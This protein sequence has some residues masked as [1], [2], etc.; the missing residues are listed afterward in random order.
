[1]DDP[2]VSS[3]P[4]AVSAGD[5]FGLLLGAAL[6]LGVGDG[7]DEGFALPAGA[8]VGVEPA[9]PSDVGVVPGALMH[10]EV[11]VTLVVIDLNAAWAAA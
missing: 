2:V 3:L 4:Y 6:E 7:P 8:G 9:A 5:G 10:H 1:V 11:F